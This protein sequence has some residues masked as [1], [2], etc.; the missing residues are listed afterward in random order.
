MNEV[1]QINSYLDKVTRNINIKLEHK[2]IQSFI[3]LIEN[4]KSHKQKKGYVH[5]AMRTGILLYNQ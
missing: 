4:E 5:I 1:E 2:N 3:F